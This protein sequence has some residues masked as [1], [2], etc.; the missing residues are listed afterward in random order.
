MKETMPLRSKQGNCHRVTQAISQGEWWT[1]GPVNGKKDTVIAK[2]FV[3][4]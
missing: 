3:V 4:K 2:V 1:L